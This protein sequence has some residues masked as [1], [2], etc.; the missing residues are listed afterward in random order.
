MELSNGTVLGALRLALYRQIP[1]HKRPSAFS[2][3][4]FQGLIQVVDQKPP[5]STKYLPSVQMVVLT[6]KGRKEIGRI[7]ASEHVAGW[8]DN[9][10]FATVLEEAA[11]A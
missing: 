10:Y 4:R 8:L 2:A 6:D 1:W 9:D 5:P 11:F 3:L 7:E